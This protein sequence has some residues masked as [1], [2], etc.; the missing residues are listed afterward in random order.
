MIIAE[1]KEWLLE[2]EVYALVEQL[3]GLIQRRLFESVEEMNKA[4]TDLVGVDADWMRILSSQGSRRAGYPSTS[5]RGE[6]AGWD[7]FTTLWTQLQPGY[8]PPRGGKTLQD[9]IADIRAK[10]ADKAQ[11]DDEIIKFLVSVAGRR[12]LDAQR[13]RLRHAMSSIDSEEGRGAF[14]AAVSARYNPAHDAPAVIGKQEVED[15]IIDELDT[16]K[17]GATA[18]TQRRLET[19]KTFVPEILAGKNI[20]DIYVPLGM[21]K[22]TAYAIMADILAACQTLAKEHGNPYAGLVQLLS[23]NKRAAEAPAA[24]VAPPAAHPSLAAPTQI[25]HPT[26]Q[27]TTSVPP[28]EEL[29]GLSH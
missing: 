5:S 3:I 19:A 29:H 22:N 14:D 18:P 20:K 6:E 1:F 2:Q 23:R 12:G 13:Q 7:V 26:G 24:P 4:I 16:M 28:P 27:A 21:N 8:T 17:D 11:Q 25:A 15:A 9:Q 10:T